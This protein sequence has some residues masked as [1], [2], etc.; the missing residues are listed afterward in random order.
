ME[1]LLVARPKEKY[2]LHLEVVANR[3]VQVLGVLGV[4]LREE[5]VG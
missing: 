1:N 5:S 4:F 2:L 3:L